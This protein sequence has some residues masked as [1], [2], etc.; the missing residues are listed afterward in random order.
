MNDV[1]ANVALICFIVF[2]V[3]FVASLIYAAVKDIK[4]ED[5]SGSTSSKVQEWLLYAVTQAE[6]IFGG[7]TGA[8]KLRYVYSAFVSKF[9]KFAEAISFDTFSSMVDVA[10]K[11]MRT[12]IED[13]SAVKEY[14]E[15]DTTETI[16]TESDTA[17]N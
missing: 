13:N 5:S 16:S 10:L 6:K 3:L 8:L 4:D 2:V 7:K 12:M 9:P 17:S 15:G 14:V 1:I 11:Q